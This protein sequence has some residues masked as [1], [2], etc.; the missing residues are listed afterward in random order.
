MDSKDE[1][2]LS[3]AEVVKIAQEFG[4]R[5]KW[6][7]AF[8]QKDPYLKKEGNKL[9]WVVNFGADQEEEIIMIGHHRFI[10]IDDETREVKRFVGPR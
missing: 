7:P 9:V 5:E 8:T 6:V 2:K 4:G 3:Q 1:A 10:T